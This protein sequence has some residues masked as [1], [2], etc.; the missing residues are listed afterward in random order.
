[1]AETPGTSTLT[2]RVSTN[3]K[4]DLDIAAANSNRSITDYVIKSIKESIYGSCLSCGR[5]P[6]PSIAAGLTMS[7]QD[8]FKGLFLPAR[9]YAPATTVASVSLEVQRQDGRR[10]YFGQVS[11]DFSLCDGVLSLRIP[12]NNPH[13]FDYE[14]PIAISEIIA[15]KQENMSGNTY[16]GDT[17]RKWIDQ[18]DINGNDLIRRTVLGLAS[19][20]PPENQRRIPPSRTSGR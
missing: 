9:E 20:K 5:G 4:D 19:P 18:G 8:W 16:T 13:S 12:I 17:F 1:M 14:V 7:F 6:L 11:K 15:W 10:A 3:L 2:I